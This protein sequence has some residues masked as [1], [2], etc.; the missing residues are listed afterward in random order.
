[1]DKEREIWK[2]SNP[3]VVFDKYYQNY[4]DGIIRISTRKNKKYMI[5]YK[6]KWVHFGDF[7]SEDFTEHLDTQ[8]RELFRQRNHK[9][10]LQER[11]TPGYLSY[12]LLW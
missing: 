5:R 1:M 8:R 3:R 10:A 9:W 4:N 6:D 12:F 11:H 7:G 2:Y